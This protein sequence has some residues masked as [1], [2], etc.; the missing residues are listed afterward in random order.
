MISAGKGKVLSIHMHPRIIWRNA[1]LRV[2]ASYAQHAYKNILW[3]KPKRM[4]KHPA[5]F[6]QYLPRSAAVEGGDPAL[7]RAGH[8]G[9]AWAEAWEPAGKLRGRA[10][11]ISPNFRAKWD[12][13]GQKERKRDKKGSNKPGQKQE[14]TLTTPLPD[15]VT[16]YSFEYF[17]FWTEA[18]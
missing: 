3:L 17:T 18:R 6:C 5:L 11:V 7:S 16:G 12:F 15:K 14:S 2:Q 1:L 4:H 10:A 9:V 8:R 13:C